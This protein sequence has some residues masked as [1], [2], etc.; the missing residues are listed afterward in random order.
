MLTE[1]VHPD[2]AAGE[3]DPAKY[4]VRL[5][6]RPDDA[7]GSWRLDEWDV[8]QARD[9][10]EVINWAEGQNATT[11][12]VAVVWPSYSQDGDGELTRSDRFIR[13]AGH[14]EEPPTTSYEVIFT[15]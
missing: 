9:V 13:I 7:T 8:R 4:R 15:T 12:E 2:D 11:Y 6:N 5:W 14:R 1:P 3:L 10:I